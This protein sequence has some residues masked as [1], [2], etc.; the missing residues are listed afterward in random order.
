MKLLPIFICESEVNKLNFIKMTIHNYIMINDLPFSISLS[1]IDPYDIILFI[2]KKKIICGTYFLDINLNSNI[3]GIDLAQI[4]RKKDPL[5]KIIFLTTHNDCALLA[6]EKKIEP[7]GYI[8][9]NKDNLKEEIIECIDIS[10]KRYLANLITENN[11]FTFS[12][13]AKKFNIPIQSIFFLETSSTAHKLIL[14]TE[15]NTYEFYSKLQNLEK[16]YPKLLRCHKTFLI[17]PEK[18]QFVDFNKRE[19][20]FSQNLKCSFSAAKRKEVEKIFQKN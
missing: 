14:H 9:T 3:N 16:T 1:S 2:E 13:G 19:I 11:V 8:L 17:N 4:I 10:Y 18:V 7:L 20:H 12:I 15:N 5:G 6:L